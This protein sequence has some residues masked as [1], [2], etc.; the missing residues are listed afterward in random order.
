M[1]T[2]TYTWNCDLCD[3]TFG[4]DEESPRGRHVCPTCTEKSQGEHAPWPD[5][6]LAA[7]GDD[8]YDT[9]TTTLLAVSSGARR[10][11]DYYSLD[12]PAREEYR[13]ESTM[14]ADLLAVEPLDGPLHRLAGFFNE[15]IGYTVADS[16][17]ETVATYEAGLPLVVVTVPSGERP[18]RWHHDSRHTFTDQHDETAHRLAKI[19]TV[20]ALTGS[21]RPDGS[22][23]ETRDGFTAEGHRLVG[24]LMDGGLDPIATRFI[25]L[26]IWTVDYVAYDSANTIVS[27]L[28][29]EAER[30][31]AA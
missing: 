24:S 21:P 6:E 18:P 29:S 8:V 14:I 9:F 5:Y 15:A 7:P 28:H 2:P 13:R 1:T 31:G 10:A 26:L 25:N 23:D 17:S 27:A 12:L 16:T 19:V 22:I 11:H 4:T 3:A 30:R 20:L